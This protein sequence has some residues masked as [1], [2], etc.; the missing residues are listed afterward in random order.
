M[1]QKLYYSN[2]I[3]NLKKDLKKKQRLFSTKFDE[4]SLQLVET[5]SLKR[6]RFRK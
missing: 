2:N 1:Y 3:E 4:S 5:S 6:E